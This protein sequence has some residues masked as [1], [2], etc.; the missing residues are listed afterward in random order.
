MPPPARPLYWLHA[1][2]CFLA[3]PHGAA[4]FLLLLCWVFRVV[5]LSRFVCVCSGPPSPPPSR[6]GNWACLVG[7]RWLQGSGRVLASVS[8]LLFSGLSCPFSFLSSTHLPSDLPNFQTNGARAHS[9]PLCYPAPPAKKSA[10][11]HHH[12]WALRGG[13]ARRRRFCFLNSTSHPTPR[14]KTRPRGSLLLGSFPLYFFATWLA[15]LRA[16][17]FLPCPPPYV[18]SFFE[19][20]FHRLCLWG[21]PPLTPSS[22]LHLPAPLCCAIGRLPA[23]PAKQLASVQLF[24]GS[25]FR[26]RRFSGVVWAG[27]GRRRR[28]A[29]G[30]PSPP[31]F[32]NRHFGRFDS[33]PRLHTVIITLRKRDLCVLSPQ[34]PSALCRTTHFP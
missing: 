18:R 26:A 31:F 6:R 28:R 13:R 5:F 16:C 9:H 15:G 17:G 12:V 20:R 24:C 11:R 34:P 8:F 19:R 3:T 22:F 21:S 14:R 7:V 1:R 4:F 33:T 2:N 27:A 30:T 10:P 32:S 23:T 25:V 29:P